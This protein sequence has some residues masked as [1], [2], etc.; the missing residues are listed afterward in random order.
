MS[1]SKRAP[2]LLLLGLA[3]VPGAAR[4]GTWTRIGPDGGSVAEIAAAPSRPSVVY[5]GLGAGGVFRSADRG[6]TW[7]FAG[8]GLIDQPIH[9]LAVDPRNPDRVYA[10]T[11]KGLLRS[12][13]GGVSWRQTASLAGGNVSTVSEVEIHP[14]QPAVLLAVAYGLGIFRSTNGGRTWT[15]E[16]V[17]PG[18]VLSLAASPVRP[19]VFWAG[20]AGGGL[21]KSVD[22]GRTWA[23]AGG[24]LPAGADI[25]E[26]AADPRAADTVYAVAQGVPGLFKSTDGG[27]TWTPSLDG[28]ESSQVRKVAVDPESSSTV[29]ALTEEQIFRSLNGG[30]SWTLLAG[31]GLQ[32]RPQTVAPLGSGVLAGTE[33]G[34]FLSTDQGATWRASQTGLTALPIAS[35]ALDGQDPLRIYAVSHLTGLY[36]MREGDASWRLLGHPVTVEPFEGFTSLVA[37]HPADPETLFA[38]VPLH[39]AKSENGGRRWTAHG[40]S[41]CIAPARIDIDPRDPA[42]L[43]TSGYTVV[44]G[45]SD[46]PGACSLFRS[47]DAGQTWT[48]LSAG[49]PLLEINPLTSALYSIFG[50]NVWTST[51]QGDTWTLLARDLH[52]SSFVASPVEEGTLWVGLS[53]RVAKSRDGGRTW[54]YSSIGLPGN[55]SVMHLAPHPT[56]PA[57]VYAGTNTHGVYRSADGGATWVRIGPWPAGL[58]LWAGIALD[59]RDPSVVY[60]G[61]DGAGVLRYEP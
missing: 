29:Y 12:A 25:L 26:I 7:T 61:T 34:L 37:V 11:N 2:L 18:F 45:C 56:D 51:D 55:D 23:A 39:I 6:R 46:G 35:L 40:V 14:R 10:A 32:G 5:A 21:F 9:D 3:A 8:K 48:C 53:G 4:A 36:K 42:T 1:L 31:T 20:F 16:P 15:T 28:L 38:G 47:R 22:S 59:P 49:G 17:L 43:Y 19:G 13:D 33:A 54:T 60:A 24:G 44:R 57:V 52:V 50:V 30:A 27:A 58:R 41:P